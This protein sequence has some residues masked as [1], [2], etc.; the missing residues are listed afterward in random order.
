M[1]IW[2][3]GILIVVISCNGQK[4]VSADATAINQENTLVLLV[5]DDYSG[6]EVAENLVIRDAKSLKKFYSKVNMTRKP[7]LPIPQV[8]FTNEMIL[9]HC[10]GEQHSPIS[11]SISILNE[12]ENQLMVK[13]E[14]KNL[15]STTESTILTSPFSVY[16]MPSSPKEILFKKEK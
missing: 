9:I 8:D 10:S 5:Q 1:R 14:T 6:S 2:I 15:E 3:L 4:K 12:T 16:K 11:T 13:I 7:G